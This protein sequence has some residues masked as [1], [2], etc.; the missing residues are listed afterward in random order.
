MILLEVG[1]PREI[2]NYNKAQIVRRTKSLNSLTMEK[3]QKQKQR[4]HQH[5]DMEIP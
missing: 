4:D 1:T 5:Q 2:I 3:N